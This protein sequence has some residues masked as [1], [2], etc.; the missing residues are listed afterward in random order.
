MTDLR[1][2]VANCPV[3]GR[4]FT[5]SITGTRRHTR[6]N[7]LKF[8]LS[9][10]DLDWYQLPA[11]HDLPFS[12]RVA[13]D[14]RFVPTSEVFVR[15]VT[16]KQVAEA[17][18]VIGDLC[19]L[20]RL[21]T[22]SSVVAYESDYEARLH[23]WTVV[24]GYNNFRAP[25]DIH[26][27][28]VIEEFIGACWPAYRRL[29]RPRRLPRV[30][31]FLVYADLT[32]VPVEGKLLLAFTALESLKTTWAKSKGIPFIAGFYRQVESNGRATPKSRRIAFEH[33]VQGMM[34][35]VK[36]RATLSRLVA[37]RNQLVHTGIAH[38]DTSWAFHQ[39]GRTVAI[40]HRYLFRLLGYRGGMADYA[41]L[42][43]RF[44]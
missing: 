36:M 23:S 29:K 22:T 24:A 3:S 38:K 44:P 40:A 16:P 2:A 30:I 12:E 20:L 19:Y 13:L 4:H 21:A 37:L 41:T 27:G 6:R 17:T 32:A 25:I 15:N 11:F 10:F 9:G 42:R 18:S 35:E 39:Y 8:T 28:R 33:L 5:T 31:D 14:G 43:R 1:F 34:S 26:D 7:H